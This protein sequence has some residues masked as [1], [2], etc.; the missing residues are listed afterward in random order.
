[1]LEYLKRKNEEL[2]IINSYIANYK[3]N[4]VLDYNGL[5]ME[6][7]RLSELLKYYYAKKYYH[8]LTNKNQFE[9][10][11]PFNYK[12]TYERFNGFIDIPNF[13]N[14][15]YNINAKIKTNNYFTNCG[16]SSIV[17]LL[18][19]IISANDINVELMYEE[20]YFETI[21]YISMISKI[22]NE[23]KVLYVDSIASDFNLKDNINYDDYEAIIIDTTCFI[24]DYYKQYIENIVK[25]KKTCIIVR[26]HTKLDLV[27]VEFSHIGSVSF[28][29]PFQCKNKD[30]IEKIE[31]DCRHL[32]GVNGACLPP[33]RFPEFMTNKELLNFNKLRIQQINKN[34]DSLYKELIK[35]KINCQ[36]PNHKLF[37][38][39]NFENS[40]LTLEM[41]KTKL[42][43]FCNT[44]R[45][46]VPIYHAVSFGFDY[47]SLDCY[48]NFNDG[49][50]KIRI[51]MNDMPEEDLHILIHNFI[52]FCNSV[53]K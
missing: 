2:A 23:K 45:N 49:K 27:G 6:K 37:C 13:T 15:F 32:I 10:T 8:E 24:G 41:L 52:T 21:K 29:Y 46:S 50:F 12:Y 3:T 36:I 7:D 22:D 42:K 44:N 38:L 5:I 31:K 19:S 1:M 28:I 30:L 14:D 48:E 39:I 16:M 26:S 20:T 53:S 9:I 25:A 43:D 11:D 35:S 17:S 33:D 4:E 18:T 34:N 40:N 47:I 51:C